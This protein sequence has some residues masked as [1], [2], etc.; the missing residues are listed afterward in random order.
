MTK[1]KIKKIKLFIKKHKYLI[2]F[3]IGILLK[4]IFKIDIKISISDIILLIS[5]LA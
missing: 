2:A 4:L 3:I 5:E 1:K